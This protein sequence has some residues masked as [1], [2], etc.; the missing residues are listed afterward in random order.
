M[1]TYASVMVEAALKKNAGKFK[2][3]DR[4]TFKGILQDIAPKGGKDPILPEPGMKLVNLT[5]LII[6]LYIVGSYTYLNLLN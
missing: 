3:N 4:I 1:A 6:T 2:K 5:I